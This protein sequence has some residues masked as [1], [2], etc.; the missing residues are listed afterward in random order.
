MFVV[1]IYFDPDL[2][3]KKY[4]LES[5]IDFRSEVDSKLD[6]WIEGTYFDDKRGV[7]ILKCSH[8]LKGFKYGRF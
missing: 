6:H 2:V 5:G 4:F 3:V 7:F 8:V 1:Q